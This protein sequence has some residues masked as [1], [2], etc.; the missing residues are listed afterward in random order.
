MVVPAPDGKLKP[1]VLAA[2]KLA[3][4]DEIYRIGG[5]QAVAALAYGTADDRAGRQDRRPR[6]RL[7]G[8]GQAPGVRH[9]RHRHDR[10]A[11]RGADPRRQRAAIPTGSPPI[12]WR[13]PSTTP[14]AQSILITDDAALADAV[15][16]RGRRAA[17][18]AAARRDRGRVA[19]AIS[20]PSSWCATSTRRS[21][22]VDAHRARASRDRDRGCRAAGRQHPQR[23]RDLPRRAHAGGDRRLCRRARTT[24]CRPRARRASPRGSACSTS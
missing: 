17:R 7:C 4:V 22:L 1:L 15:E 9:G 16:T 12:C 18:D 2:A 21:P 23:R 19:G 13:R 10:R 14:R 11:L 24:C 5:A 3:G 6:Q 20:A 8:G